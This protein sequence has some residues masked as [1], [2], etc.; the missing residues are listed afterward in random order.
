MFALN[1][2]WTHIIKKEEMVYWW[3]VYNVFPPTAML[4]PV[5]RFISAA[6]YLLKE[7]IVCLFYLF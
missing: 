6:A 5:C 3:Y 2:H 7:R 4:G 1:W